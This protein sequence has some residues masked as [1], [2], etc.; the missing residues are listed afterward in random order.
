VELGDRV[1]VEAVE[2]LAKNIAY[3]VASAEC[4]IIAPIPGERLVGVELPNSDR[5]EVLLGDVLRAR[6]DNPDR[7]PLLVA[8]GPVCTACHD[9]VFAK[10]GA[11]PK[12]SRVRTLTG[13]GPSGEP[14]CGPCTIARHRQQQRLRDVA[15]HDIPYPAG[16]GPAVT[17]QRRAAVYCRI[18]DDREGRELGVDRQ[19]QASTSWSRSAKAVSS[20]FMPA[21]SMVMSLLTTK[22]GGVLWVNCWA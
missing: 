12:C 21:S 14:E 4:R 7:H 20:A 6:V 18:S 8:R 9:Q 15:L 5:E 19:R 10:P 16:Y 3:A 17:T 13:V 11:C 1:K 22:P 2:K